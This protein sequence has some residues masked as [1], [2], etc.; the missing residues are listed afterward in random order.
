MFKRD[1][2]NNQFYGINYKIVLVLAERLPG[3]YLELSKESLI[4]LCGKSI[5]C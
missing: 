3:I 5:L 2:N 1:E 4:I